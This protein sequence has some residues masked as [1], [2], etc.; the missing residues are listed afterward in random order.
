MFYRPSR[1]PRIA[2]QVVL[3]VLI[4]VIGIWLGGHQSWLPSSLRGALVDNSEGQLVHQV[5][6][7]LSSNYYRPVNRGQLVNTGLAAAVA[8]LNDP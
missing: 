3:A 4:L 8:S 1:A 7:L 2:A 6:D 5:L